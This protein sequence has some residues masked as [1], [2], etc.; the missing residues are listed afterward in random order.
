MRLQVP[1]IFFYQTLDF[2]LQNAAA[3]H[4]QGWRIFLMQGKGFHASA[5]YSKAASSI[6]LILVS[7][8]AIGITPV[9]N[10]KCP[11]GL[12]MS[13]MRLTS[14]RVSAALQWIILMSS[15]TPQVRPRLWIRRLAS[16]RFAR[17]L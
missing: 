3:D 11:P 4:G 2:F 1:V 9:P 17:G 7:G 13:M 12:P 8:T 16:A 5:P 14:A 6:A 15:M 10:R